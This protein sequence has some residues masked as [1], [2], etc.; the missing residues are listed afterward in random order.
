MRYVD[1]VSERDFD[2]LACDVDENIRPLC[3]E[4]WRD[5]LTTE[6]SQEDLLRSANII[7]GYFGSRRMVTDVDWDEEGKC[8]LWEVQFDQ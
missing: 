6:M 4:M 8:F 7:L 5:D 3:W 1:M 2:D